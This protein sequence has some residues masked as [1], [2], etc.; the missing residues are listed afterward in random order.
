MRCD[1]CGYYLPN[2]ATWS[3]GTAASRNSGDGPYVN[4]S[5]VLPGDLYVPMG[6]IASYSQGGMPPDDMLHAV[7]MLSQ[8]TLKIYSMY[9]PPR[10][11]SPRRRR[12]PSPNRIESTPSIPDGVH[13]EPHQLPS[14]SVIRLGVPQSYSTC[15]VLVLTHFFPCFPLV[16]GDPCVLPPVSRLAILSVSVFFLVVSSSISCDR[17]FFRWFAIATSHEANVAGSPGPTA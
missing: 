2:Q 5:P 7:V 10:A 13:F 4:G 11:S 8:L 17:S 6:N 15:S 14:Q 3:A 12:S 9:N 1:R 16:F